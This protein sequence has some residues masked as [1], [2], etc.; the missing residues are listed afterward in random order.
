MGLYWD[1]P[2]WHWDDVIVWDQS[3]LGSSGGTVTFPFPDATGLRVPRRK[4]HR[5]H[6]WS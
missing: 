2:S 5:A 4:R 1:D 3:P 6:Y